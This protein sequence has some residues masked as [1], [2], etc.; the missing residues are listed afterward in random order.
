MRQLIK[1][2]ERLSLDAVIVAV[3]WGIALGMADMLSLLVLG[4]ATW[5]TYVA[6]RL[7]D[8][9]YGLVVPGTD[10]HLYYKNNYKLFRNLWI[11]GFLAVAVLAGFSLPL[12]KVLW[13]CLLVAGIVLY[14]WA[15]PKMTGPSS[16]LILKRLV[17]PLIFAA[18]V[19]WMAES[20]RSPEGN[21][22][23][24]V[25][26]LGASTNVLLISYWENRDKD[27]VRWLPH[28]LG[29]ALIGLFC[30]SQLGLLYYLQ[31][32]LSGLVCTV[33]YFV[34]LLWVQAGRA[35]A[36]RSWSDG[37]LAAAGVVLILLK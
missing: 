25:L 18:G 15:I 29:G 24:G 22:A 19:G 1:W 20:W 34:I 16:R 30:L 3:V 26:L 10:R 23:T 35:Q 36:V 6:D 7:R 14:L 11:V 33:V 8:C 17:V 5:L 32:G 9:G 21:F 2:M 27:R 13:G 31:E 12:W 28:A 4:M 37:T